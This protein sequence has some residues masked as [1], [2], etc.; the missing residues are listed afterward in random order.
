MPLETCRP[1]TT[2]G[3]A[4][5]ALLLAAT[6]ACA[7]PAPAQSGRRT[8]P[9]A[10][11]DSGA[12][13]PGTPAPAAA[14]QSQKKDEAAKI[15]VVVVRHTASANVAA[16]T[17]LVHRRLLRRLGEAHG[18]NVSE[19]KELNRKEAIDLAKSRPDAYVVWFEM[20]I[21]LGGRDINMDDEKA[22]N[23]ALN[24]GCLLVHYAVFAPGT[25]RQKS[26]G[27]VYQDGYESTC[28]GTPAH[29]S[30]YPDAPPSRQH[31]PPEYAIPKAAGE[32]ADRIMSDL[33]VAAPIR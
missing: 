23:T 25:G 30:P 15:S 32:A 6:L 2:R 27:R 21:D 14:E 22:G 20:A 13:R 17:G 3:P 29:P 5:A 1:S 18:L 12:D 16:W 10:P 24:P 26:T 19:G 11:R 7:L 9:P 28:A 33:G 31:R 8:P 4:A